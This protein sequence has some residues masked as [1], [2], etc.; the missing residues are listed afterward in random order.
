V[1]DDC[2]PCVV[3]I[4]PPPLPLVFGDEYPRPLSSCHWDDLLLE[5]QDAKSIGKNYEVSF[6][7]DAPTCVKEC[8]LPRTLCLELLCSAPSTVAENFYTGDD[9]DLVDSVI[10]SGEAF[11]P[12]DNGESDDTI[13]RLQV[14]CRALEEEVREL[15]EGMRDFA[16]N[17][18]ATSSVDVTKAVTEMV[19]KVLAAFALTMQTNCADMAKI[20]VDSAFAVMKVGSIDCIF[21]ED[22]IDCTIAEEEVDL[23]D[24]SLVCGAE[25]F[26][27][28]KDTDNIVDLLNGLKLRVYCF[29][30]EKEF[31]WNINAKNFE[32][33]LLPVVEEELIESWPKKVQQHMKVYSFTRFGSVCAKSAKS[34]KFSDCANS[35]ARFTP[36]IASSSLC[37]S[38]HEDKIIRSAPLHDSSC[39]SPELEDYYNSLVCDDDFEDYF[40]SSAC[41]FDDIDICPSGRVD[42]QEPD[43]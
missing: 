40:N 37:V 35:C 26:V 23:I 36:V 6:F 31:V 24:A 1:T 29:P 30:L 15:K 19:Q 10:F 18:A 38:L 34:A 28:L 14:E 3:A 7:V 21:S 42:T 33:P 43:A 17:L 39:M 13:R 25:Q 5:E 4:P 41:S 27:A 2:G 9:S 32:P 22:T 11:S 12:A 20:A 16:E 8:S